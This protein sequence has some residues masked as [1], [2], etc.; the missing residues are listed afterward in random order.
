MNKS[1][2][3][4]TNN[5]S[6][7]K[8]PGNKGQGRRT[9]SSSCNRVDRNVNDNHSDIATVNK[10][11]TKLKS[12]VTECSKA[13]KGKP[14]KNSTEVEEE[15]LDYEDNVVT[16]NFQE[17]DQEVEMAVRDDKENEF[18]SEQN[19][20]DDSEEEGE[21]KDDNP[22][23]EPL[24]RPVQVKRKVIKAARRRS[25]EDKVDEL[26]TTVLAMQEMMQEKGILEEFK[27]KIKKKGELDT[28]V[29]DTTI[30]KEAVR[31]ESELTRPEESSIVETIETL[32]D[33]EITFKEKRISS[34]SDEPIDT[35][36]EL[37]D[38][39][40]N[41]IADCAREGQRMKQNIAEETG[42]RSQSQG[43]RLIHQT[44]EGRARAMATP[45]NSQG[46][47]LNECNPHP[48]SVV[49]ENYVVIRGNLDK[50]LRA[51]I[52]KHEYVDFA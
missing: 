32:V 40:D 37:L 48:A 2:K 44:E 27:S 33:P 43:D 7:N 42:K 39:V 24:V 26:S 30:Y 6:F 25:V 35:S 20:S 45:G 3:V 46:I 18:P 34:S 1:K 49:D 36:D 52:I 51:K 19:D 8:M 13:K 21:L 11:K 9:R 17:D 29:S 47:F 4:K 50:G 14:N 12:V 31:Q 16:V 41:F 23:E 38:D 15:L 10:R 5:L 22:E 28:S